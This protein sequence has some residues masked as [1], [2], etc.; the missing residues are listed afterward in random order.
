MY[1]NDSYVSQAALTE[2]VL[3]IGRQRVAVGT[4]AAERAERVV[5]AEGAQVAQLAA[6]VHVLTR[7]HGARR[8]ARLAGALETALRVATGAVATDA[9]LGHALVLIWEE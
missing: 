9:R 6:L 4:D 5:A 8:E 3:A 7:L 1:V 2:T